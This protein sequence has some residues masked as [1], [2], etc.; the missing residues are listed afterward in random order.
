MT[1]IGEIAQEIMCVS[2]D[3]TCEK[4]DMLFQ[5]DPKL[6]GLVVTEDELSAGLIT[7]TNFYQKMGTRY[8][9]NLF[10]KRPVKLLANNSPLI[11]DYFTSV[12]EVSKQAMGRRDEEVYDDVIVR[13][14]NAIYGVVSI[15]ELLLKGADIQAN[16]ARY[17]N[18]LT[19]LPGNYIIDEKLKNLFRHSSNF[20]FLYIDL[21]RFKPYNDLYGFRKGDEFLQFTATT[22]KECFS[23]PDCFIGHVGGDDFVVILNHFDFENYCQ[24]V[25]KTFDNKVQYFYSKEHYAQKTAYGE[26]RFG[27]MEAI[28]L[29]SISIAIVKNDYDRFRNAEELVA[30]ATRLKKICKVKSG[31]CYY[32]EPSFVS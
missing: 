6:Q 12:I 30:E 1:Y 18:P 9:Y 14:D 24:D 5:E 17:L 26:N 27:K 16:V 28:P 32:I 31:S 15:K 8:G 29:V 11:V 7:R 2:F 25:I 23:A 20:T 22:L 13:K 4:V 19:L 21:D 3:T 10:L